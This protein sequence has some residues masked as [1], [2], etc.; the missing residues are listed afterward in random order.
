MKE[1]KKRQISNNLVGAFEA[2]ADHFW[3]AIHAVLGLLNDSID[4]GKC[5]RFPN[6]RIFYGELQLLHVRRNLINIVQ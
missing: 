4:F 5:G 2:S 1:Q 3:D 6:S